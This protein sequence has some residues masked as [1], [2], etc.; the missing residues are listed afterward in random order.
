MSAGAPT[1]AELRAARADLANAAPALR[2]MTIAQRADAIERA[3]RLLLDPQSRH[4]AQLRDELLRTSGLS[5]PVIEHGLRTTLSLFT[6]DGLC[7][8]IAH[9]PRSA[10][11][12]RTPQL[13][14]VILAG[15]VFSAAARPLLLPLACGASVLAKAASDD[16]ALPRAL[17]GALATSD[18][19]LG[20]AC[21][22]ARYAHEDAA[23]TRELLAGAELISVYGSDDTVEAVR[24]TADPAARVL[25]HGHGLG[26]VFVA[27]DALASE[28]SARAAAERIALD[29]AAYDQR[30]CLSPHF[31][32]V[33]LGAAVEA[34]AFARFLAD[35]LHAIERTLPRG[36][37]PPAAA[38]AQLQWRGV[39]AALGELHAHERCAV[40]YEAGHPPRPS[41][42]HRNLSV[43]DCTDADAAHAQLARLGDHLKALAI[44][45]PNASAKL[46][47]VAPYV[48]G[49]GAMQ[50]PPLD[51]ALDRLHPL[52]GLTA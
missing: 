41:P 18:P 31:A 15:N 26:A 14:T 27:G 17:H 23:L 43:H 49:F 21:T 2:A 44:A 51:A 24:A 33:E 1:A 48:C 11:T 50:T 16:D 13:A 42:G 46:A 19:R 29:V 25:A 36:A 20:A 39:A 4:G 3:C 38:A 28:T 52:A 30:G 9:A 34:R 5:V 40:S 45:A 37:L 47:S 10:A 6:R 8:L 12:A 7:T 35:A 32:L 22:V